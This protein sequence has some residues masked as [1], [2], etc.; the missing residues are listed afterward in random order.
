MYVMSLNLFFSNLVFNFFFFFTTNSQ[1]PNPNL[2]ALKD[3][4]GAFDRVVKM[5]SVP[6]P[7]GWY[8][9]EMTQTE[10]KSSE[11]NAK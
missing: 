6:L 8:C 5:F 10:K 1:L 4:I 11:V 2:K 9:N 3:K 7:C